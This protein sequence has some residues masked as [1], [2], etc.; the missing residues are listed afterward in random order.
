MSTMISPRPRPCAPI[1]VFVSLLFLATATL[2]LDNQPAYAQSNEEI[3]HIFDQSDLPWAGVTLDK[4]GNVYGTSSYGGA[5]HHGAVYEATHN[6][7]GSWSYA[8]LYSFHGAGDPNTPYSGVVFDSAGN[9]Y[10]STPFG[11]AFGNGAVYEL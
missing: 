6:P 9:L 11:G 3:L 7:D 1:R 5:Y 8:L 10:G 4:E 2:L